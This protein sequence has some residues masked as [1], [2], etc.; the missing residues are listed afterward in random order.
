MQLLHPDPIQKENK[1]KEREKKKKMRI[2]YFFACFLVLHASYGCF[3]HCSRADCCLYNLLMAVE[4]S[5]MQWQL[6]CVVRNGNRAV[7]AEQH[8]KDLEATSNR[9]LIKETLLIPY[10]KILN[11]DQ[12]K[13]NW[14]ISFR[15]NH[16][17][18]CRE[19]TS[20]L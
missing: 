13:G 1:Q 15:V 4:C 5:L 12:Y 7:I 8:V 3:R 16:L 6:S 10:V 9:R 18:V 19:V 20:V 17:R 2:V 14:G 11:S